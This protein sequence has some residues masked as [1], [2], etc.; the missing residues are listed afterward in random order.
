MLLLPK[1]SARREDAREERSDLIPRHGGG[2]ATIE[3]AQLCDW[4]TALHGCVRLTPK[5]PA[6]EECQPST[7][8]YLYLQDWLS[9]ALTTVLSLSLTFQGYNQKLLEPWE[10]NFLQRAGQCSVTQ[11]EICCAVLTK[12]PHCFNDLTGWSLQKNLRQTGSW[13]MTAEVRPWPSYIDKHI[14]VCT[15]K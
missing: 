7:Q 14:H 10:N 6:M 11:W 3:S 1:G 5:C 2:G 13:K 12:S 4:V 8:C 15:Y 9:R